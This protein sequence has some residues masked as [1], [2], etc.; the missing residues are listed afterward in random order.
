MPNDDIIIYY[1]RDKVNIIK[2]NLNTFK[3]LFK[4]LH[5]IVY[6]NV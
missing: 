2:M 1:A 3:N 5:I 4:H 6:Y